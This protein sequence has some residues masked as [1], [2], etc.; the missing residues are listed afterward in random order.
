MSVDSKRAYTIIGGG[1][2]LYGYLPAIVDRL[3]L[4]VVLPFKYKEKVEARPELLKTLPGIEWVKDQ[5]T[6]LAAASGVVI[7][8]PPLEQEQIVVRC[9]ALPNLERFVLEKPVAVTPDRAFRILSKLE[10]AGK[11]YAV[12]YTLLHL[13]W[14]DRQRWPVLPAPEINLS[15]CFMAHHFKRDLHSWKRFHHEGGGVL[16]FFGIHLV[17]LLASRNYTEVK[18]SRLEGRVL[19]GPERWTAVFSGV[20]L[21][22]CHVD[23]DSRSATSAFEIKCG[24]GKTLSFRQDSPFSGEASRDGDDHRVTALANLLEQ[25]EEGRGTLA[26]TLVSTYV[27]TNSLWH[28]V[29][30]I[31]T[32]HSIPC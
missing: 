28:R 32:Y 22:D 20:G 10:A 2:G 31:S 5:D 14:H 27:A 18:Q 3:E 1:F 4:R 7:A 15:W 13:D 25:L 9:L 19:D 23:V 24:D 21:P 30:Q 6:A 17:A 8:C 16:R 26:G 11:S 12:G 29:E